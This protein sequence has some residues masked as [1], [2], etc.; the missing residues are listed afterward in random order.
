MET[1]AQQE[2]KAFLELIEVMKKLEIDLSIANHQL[3]MARDRI[4]QLEA[5]VYGG[6]TQ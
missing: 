2:T 1:L 3:A 6:T 5:E 4:A